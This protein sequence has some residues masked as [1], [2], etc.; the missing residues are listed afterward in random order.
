M[1][2][3][4]YCC[5]SCLHRFELKRSFSDNSTVTCPRCSSSVRQ[6]YSPAPIIFKGSG[7]YVTDVKRANE[8]PET[9]PSKDRS[10]PKK[11]TVESKKAED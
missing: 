1:P 4:E 3:Y 9:P 6:V 11:E 5:D 7:F 2:I 10:T 8:K